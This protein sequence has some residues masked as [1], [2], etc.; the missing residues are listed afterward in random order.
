[1]AC[2]ASAKVHN[3]NINSQ[4]KAWPEAADDALQILSDSTEVGVD[5]PAR[6]RGRVSIINGENRITAD[7]AQISAN[8]DTLTAQGGIEFIT[9]NVTVKSDSLDANMVNKV[10]QLHNSNYQ[11]DN[12]MGHGSAETFKVDQIKRQV[13]LADASFTNCPPQ[14][15]PDWQIKSTEIRLDI[16]EEWGQ[17]WH[18]RIEVFEVPILYLPYLSFPL[19]DKRKSGFL[20]PSISTSSQRGLDISVPYYWN[21]KENLDATLTTRTMTDRGVQLGSEVRYL[22]QAYNGEL[23]LEWMPHD[24]QFASLTDGSSAQRSAMTWQHQNYF[25]NDW[26]FDADLTFVSDDSYVSDLEFRDINS[27]DTYVEREL[28]LQK[29]AKDWTLDISIRD[30]EVFGQHVKPYRTLPE[31]RY[32]YG[33]MAQASGW[34]FEMPVEFAWFQAR[35]TSLPEAIRSHIEPELSWSIYQPAW[36]F[37]AETSLPATY[38]RQEQMQDG[39]VLKDNYQTITRV[40][41]RFRMN[42]RLVFERP[43]DWFGNMMVQTLEPRAQYLYVPYRDQSDIGLYDTA[44]LQ[45]DYLGLFREN[46]FSGLDRIPESNQIT[47]GVTTRLLNDESREKLR[48]SVGQ[49]LFLTESRTDFVDYRETTERGESALAAELDFDIRKTWFLHYGLQYDTENQ[50]TSKSQLTIDYY[51]DDAH[52]VQLGHRYVRD[53]SGNQIQQVNLTSLWQLNSQWRG[54]ASYHYDLELDRT[55][56]SRIGLLYE[57]C[58]WQLSFGWQSKIKSDLTADDSQSSVATEQRD[59]GML[60]SFTIR[61]FGA[62][63]TQSAKILDGGIFGYRKPYF[64]NQ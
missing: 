29:I 24:R 3:T 53:V 19:S 38:Y 58:C 15:R 46:R 8:R 9:P 10:L 5:Q 30:F 18:S 26:L 12:F 54:Y 27:V 11:L 1:M 52:I 40:L 61:G 37:R 35:D 4:Q 7:S 14:N 20:Y 42:G 44:L 25:A 16:E 51:V 60:L 31:V 17:A 22:G 23:Y 39:E 32:W 62:N 49:I 2:Y 13:S 41:P 47:L 63:S 43:L 50:E 64:L 56:E 55:V 57:S 6:F 28:N 36:D 59:S 48:L 34:S 33:G 21:I 45:D